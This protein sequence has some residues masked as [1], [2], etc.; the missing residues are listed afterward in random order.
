MKKKSGPGRAFS[1][2]C[3]AAALVLAGCATAPPDEGIHEVIPVALSRELRETTMQRTWIG[4]TH[5]ELIRAFGA[6]AF[7]LEV[8]GARLP[9]SYIVVFVGVDR[10]GQCIDAFV[11]LKDRSATIWNYFCR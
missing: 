3:L 8:P 7:M 6:P 11:V 2:A 9:E 10:A 5:D 1:R 4:R